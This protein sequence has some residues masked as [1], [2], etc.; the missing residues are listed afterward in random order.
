M[1]LEQGKKKKLTILTEFFKN[2][3]ERERGGGGERE[4]ERERER[5]SSNSETVVKAANVTCAASNR[6][7]MKSVTIGQPLTRGSL[8]A[9][10]Q[11]T[12]SKL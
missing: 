6:A 8:T 11:L 3:R 1:V 12:A 4:R 2:E 9:Q 5:E 10:P 7:L